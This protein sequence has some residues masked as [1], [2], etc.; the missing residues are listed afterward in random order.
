MCC[1]CSLR[2]CRGGM[3]T[4]PTMPE[5]PEQ[6]ASASRG[7]LRQQQLRRRIV[8]WPRYFARTADGE[9]S[10]MCGV[11]LR[12][13]ALMNALG[14]LGN[15]SHLHLPK[16]ATTITPPHGAQDPLCG[17]RRGMLLLA[18]PRRMPRATGASIAVQG[19]QGRRGQTAERQHER[20]N[21][22]LPGSRSRD[23]QRE[24]E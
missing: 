23:L 14:F 12:K 13:R 16:R 7:A 18:S 1:V 24:T 9:R 3:A 10:K 21:S 8:R 5:M 2:A 11:H 17:L 15:F 20:Q 6:R 19:P 22:V 4:A